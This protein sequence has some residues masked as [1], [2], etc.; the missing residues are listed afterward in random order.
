MGCK[1]WTD[2]LLHGIHQGSVALPSYILFGTILG[3]C[4]PLFIPFGIYCALPFIPGWSVSQLKSGLER[5]MIN[6]ERRDEEEREERE[7]R[8][9]EESAG[10]EVEKNKEN[11]EAE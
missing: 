1:R 6:E 11:V 8:E 4:W 3:I 2:R 10:V 7:E 5:K 9:E